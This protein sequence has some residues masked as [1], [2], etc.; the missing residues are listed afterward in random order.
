MLS[1]AMK[2]NLPFVSLMREIE[3]LIKIQ[4]DTHKVLCRLFEKNI[5]SS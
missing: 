3:S 1:Q 2:D 5:H 4:R